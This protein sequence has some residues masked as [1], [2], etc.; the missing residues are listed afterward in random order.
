[1][2]TSLTARRG[3]T[4]HQVFPSF[5]ADLPSSVEKVYFSD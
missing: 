1:M 3:E 4:M 2:M 5:I